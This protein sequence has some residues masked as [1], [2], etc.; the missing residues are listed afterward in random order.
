[1]SKYQNDER[2]PAMGETSMEEAKE[3]GTAEALAQQSGSQEELPALQKEGKATKTKAPKKPKKPKKPWT[4]KRIITLVVVVVLVLLMAYSC[5]AQPIM[6]ASAARSQVSLAM[7]ITTLSPREIVTSI[8][9]TGIVESADKHYVYSTMAAYTVMEVPV[10][11]GDVVQ[12]GDILCLLDDSAVKD[13][14]ASSELSL[15]QSE[16]AAKQQVKSARD[17]YNALQ[18]T[19]YDGTNSTLIS[20]QAQVT[21][22]YNAYLSAVDNYN[23]YS[24]N[25]SKAQS[26]LSEKQKD[27]DDAIDAV[28]QIENRDQTGETDE[29]K[30]EA[31]GKLALA[32][33][34]QAAAQL[35]YDSAKA[36]YDSLS[37]QGSALSRAVDSAYNAYLTALKSMDAAVAAVE[38]QI[39]SSK[40]QLDSTKISAETAEKTKELTLAQLESSLDDTIVR[41]PT[42]GTV[43]AVYAEVGAPGSGLLFVIED[44]DDL[45]V[46]TT[47]KAFDVG[48]V[49]TGLDVTIKSDA[50]GDEVYDGTV[51]FISPATQKTPTGDTN[52]ISEVFDAEVAV[53]SKNTGLRI[54]MSVRLNYIV[55]KQENVLAVP[56]DAVYT[57]ASGQDAVMAAMDN[58]KGKYVLTEMPVTLG[59]ESD[60]YVVISGEGIVEGLRILNDPEGRLPGEVITLV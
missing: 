26:L 55:E 35:A 38:T 27:L 47:V 40:N 3:N 58:G 5:V 15:T 43:T 23:S 51:T 33:Q 46:K 50:T 8:G 44:V 49:K 25:L 20:A 56:Y 10:E 39:Q 16:K 60:L 19:V 12:E 21:S 48:T 57:N 59:I 29:Q 54:G 53:N 14:I 17:S 36:S 41:A 24:S 18:A 6:A 52:T 2:I 22:A 28:K 7:G 31:E 32:Q 11:V 37:G 30:A 9:A 42:S 34:S 45:I 13:Q 1:M 4:R